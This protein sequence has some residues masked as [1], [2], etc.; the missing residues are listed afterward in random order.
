MLE[1]IIAEAKE[2]PEVSLAA[3]QEYNEKKDF[4]IRQVN[5]VLS[6][7]LLKFLKSIQPHF[8]AISV[9]MPF[10][11]ERVVKVIEEIKGSPELEQLKVMVGEKQRERKG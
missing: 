6:K 1:K 10:N 3:A 4:L 2:L 11:L 8:L 9:S 5:E 7:D